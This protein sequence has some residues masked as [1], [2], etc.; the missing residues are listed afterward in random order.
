M[1]FPCRLF[2][3]L[4][5][6]SVFLSKTRFPGEKGGVLFLCGKSDLSP[7]SQTTNLRPSRT[8]KRTLKRT[9]DGTEE[10]K[11]MLKTQLKEKQ[12]G[13]LDVV[14]E[15]GLRLKLS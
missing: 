4:S 2:L 1:C 9:P 7:E 3:P 6:H 12:G 10:I 8:V 5:F 13:G 11:K 15:T 14:N